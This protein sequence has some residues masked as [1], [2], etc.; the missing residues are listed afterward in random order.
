MDKH[1][2]R[3]NIMQSIYESID[4][5]KIIKQYMRALIEICKEDYPTRYPNIFRE[6]M[7]YINS[8]DKAMIYSGLNDRNAMLIQ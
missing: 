8:N 3:D 1:F 5:I 6:I 7:N 2:V 4:N